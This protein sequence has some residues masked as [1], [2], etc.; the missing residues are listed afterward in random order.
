MMLVVGSLQAFENRYECI[1]VKV[2][3]NGETEFY[4]DRQA[5]AQGVI[6]LNVTDYK[7]HML[8]ADEQRD[9]TY[10]ETFENDADVYSIK[11]K[12]EIWVIKGDGLCYITEGVITSTYR[13]TPAWCKQLSKGNTELGSI[14][15][16]KKTEIK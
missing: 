13:N 4:T 5:T 15:K 1:L 12:S 10:V 16:C 3:F 11:D 9:F 2:V 14:I 6:I 7:A 8:V